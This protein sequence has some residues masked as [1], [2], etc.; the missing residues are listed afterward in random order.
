MTAVAAQPKRQGALESFENV[1]KT[2]YA[3]VYLTS[4]TFLKTANLIETFENVGAKTLLIASKVSTV[5]GTTLSSLSFMYILSVFSKMVKSIHA[6]VIP[7]GTDYNASEKFLNAVHDVFDFIKNSGYL[8]GSLNAISV[9]A[10]STIAQGTVGI[11]ISGASLVIDSIEL[12]KNIKV[13]RDN[14][15][16]QDEGSLEMKRLAWID[17]AK[18]VTGIAI[19]II[20]FSNIYVGAALCAAKAVIAVRH[21]L[22]LE[23][24]NIFTLWTSTMY[25]EMHPGKKEDSAVA[26][27]EPAQ[28][29]R[30]RLER[31]EIEARTRACNAK[32]ALHEETLRRLQAQPAVLVPA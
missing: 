3:G 14:W 9:V 8:V 5:F 25:K 20:A 6:Y 23:L 22:I 31:D 26:V 1:S 19:A 15:D 30:D 21:L 18:N 4:K 10:L 28:V 24:F 12:F 27:A 13:L 29:T 32:A 16:K 7:T 2:A 17:I 11:V